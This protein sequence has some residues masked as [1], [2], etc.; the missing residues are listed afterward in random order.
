MAFY[1]HAD[2]GC[3]P[4]D[5]LMLWMQSRTPLSLRW[6][7]V[8]FDILCVVVGGL[9]GG[10]LGVGTVLSALLSGPAMCAVLNRLGGQSQ[11]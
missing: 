8:G 5:G 11:T 4:T 10:S 6:F 1:L 7:K 3:G 9:L 2:L